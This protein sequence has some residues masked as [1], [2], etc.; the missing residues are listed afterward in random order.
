[1]VVLAGT[2][3]LENSN[4]IVIDGL[5]RIVIAVFTIWKLSSDMRNLTLQIDPYTIKRSRI[6]QFFYGILFPPKEL[7]RL[8]KFVVLV[9]IA[10]YFVMSGLNLLEQQ[11][12]NLYYLEETEKLSVNLLFLG[13]QTPMMMASR[14][15]VSKTFSD[16]LKNLDWLQNS[17][18]STSRSGAG[19]AQ[20]TNYASKE[21]SF[22]S[23]N[24]NGKHLWFSVFLLILLQA[25]EKQILAQDQLLESVT[26]LFSIIWVNIHNMI[27]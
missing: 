12:V 4:P 26:R 14:A 20:S 5:S 11:D 23:I 7:F 18:Y 22:S 9:V 15:N 25:F 21:I 1:G 16:Y 17:M 27:F 19:L 24:S 3:G 8:L 10:F 13:I 6:V 2:R